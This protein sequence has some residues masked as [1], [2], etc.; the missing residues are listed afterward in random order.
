FRTWIARLAAALAARDLRLLRVDVGD[1]GDV[2]LVRRRDPRVRV[3]ALLPFFSVGRD[4]TPLV[5]NDSL[6]WA[7]TVLAAS[8]DYP[9]AAHVGADASDGDDLSSMRHAGTAVVNAATGAVRLIAAPE[10]DADIRAWYARFP[11][12][13]TRA[14]ALDSSIAAVLPVPY[15]AA[16]AQAR[17]Y[18]EYGPRG[19]RTLPARRVQAAEFADSGP[20]NHAASAFVVAGAG[21]AATAAVSFPVVTVT[22]RVAGV[23]VATGGAVP[24]TTWIA[25]P[26]PGPRWA[27]LL[28]STAVDAPGAVGGAPTGEPTGGRAT[29]ST[30]DGGLHAVPTA[31]GLLFTRAHYAAAPDGRPTLVGVTA[32]LG[33]RVVRGPTLRALFDSA[34]AEGDGAPRPTRPLTGEQRVAAARGFYDDARRALQRGDWSAFGRALDA[35]GRALAAPP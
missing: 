7:V 14:E 19:A 27:D 4:A 9:L 25:A 23:I 21:R 13:A 24:R 6:W 15:D 2:R 10:P 35:I 16:T 34:T 33:D 26:E 20:T 18:A 32:V 8:G 30:L 28:D 3:Q 29:Q 5:A 12:L 17:V 31:A 11:R 22:D 1:R